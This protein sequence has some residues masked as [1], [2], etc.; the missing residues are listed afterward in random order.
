M[1]LLVELGKTLGL[2]AILV[3]ALI[4]VVVGHERLLRALLDWQ[5]RI[6]AVAPYLGVMIAI[7]LVRAITQDFAEDV[8]WLLDL[9]L[10]THI[11][12]FEGDFIAIFQ[13]IAWP[14]LSAYLGFMYL[15][16]YVVLISFPAIAYFALPRID[17]L[18]E[19][20]VAYIVND[21]IGIM[22]YVLFIS[23]GPRNLGVDFVDPILYDMYPQAAIMTGAVNI[24]INV[25][26]SLHTSMA[27]TAMFFAWRT[28]R[29]Y[30]SWSIIATVFATSIIFSTMY[31]G[32]HW[33][34]D[35]V[36]GIA[37]ATLSI[38]IAV[39]F[40]QN[41]LSLDILTAYPTGE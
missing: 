1:S 37:L 3:I 26:P 29:L 4:L 20:I 27:A 15:Y 22:F 17:Y 31:L 9:N 10:T 41:D 16:G 35:V 18:K 23:Y 34:S 32:I 12:A 28:R 30:P 25:F 6:R 21:T 40:V 8:T 5:P 33:A 24:P 7:L 39:R 19:L 36:A 11:F 38:L 2:S 14:P 13:S